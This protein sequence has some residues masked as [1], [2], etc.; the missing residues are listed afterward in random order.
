MLLNSRATVITRASVVRP[1]KPKPFSR[2]PLNRLMS[3]FGERYIFTISP[4]C[5]FFVL[6]CFCFIFQNFTF[7]IFYDICFVFVT[8]GPT[9]SRKN[10]KRHILWKYITVLIPPKSCILLGFYRK[11]Y[12]PKLYNE[13]WNFKFLFS[14]FL[15]F[16]LFYFLFLAT[17]Y[18]GSG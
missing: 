18:L 4:D 1:W 8:M 11:I 3:N 6:F 12:L 13:L 7:L 15:L 14:F 16:F 5:F 10:A 17:L 9:K 2:Y